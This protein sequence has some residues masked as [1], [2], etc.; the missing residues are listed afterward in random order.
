MN[1]AIIILII[2]L[3]FILWIITAARQ[4]ARRINDK[5][6]KKIPMWER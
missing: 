6:L 2:C 5:K 1:V 3:L 4:E